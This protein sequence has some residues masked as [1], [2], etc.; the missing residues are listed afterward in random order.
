MFSPVDQAAAWHSSND[1]FHRIIF[2][3]SADQRLA[4]PT[5]CHPRLAG[6]R[7]TPICRVKRRNG[8]LVSGLPCYEHCRSDAFESA[9]PDP[10]HSLHAPMEYP[11]PSSFPSFF[12]AQDLRAELRHTP[13]GI[14]TRPRSVPMVS[15]LASGH[16]LPRLFSQYADFVGRRVRR[17]IDWATVGILDKDETRQLRDDLWTLRDNFGEGPEEASGGDDEEPAEEE[18]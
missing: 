11:L 12:R 7:Q 16:T 4:L 9:L 8:T 17:K 15:T 3:L 10:P 14:L 5:G 1:N 2:A 13:H 18:V 6:A